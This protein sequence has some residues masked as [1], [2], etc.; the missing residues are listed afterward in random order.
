M[1][2]EQTTSTPVDATQ[3]VT[4][5]VEE[6][7][8]ETLPLPKLDTVTPEQPAT[9]TSEDIP[10]HGNEDSPVQAPDRSVSATPST[11]AQEGNDA[12]YINKIQTLEKQVALL[13]KIADKAAMQR[14]APEDVGPSQ[15][16]VSVYEGQI[17]L[18]WR[19]IRDK[20]YLKNHELVEE[21]VVE[22]TLA[23]RSTRILSYK[24]TIT[25]VEKI[26]VNVTG[27][28]TKDAIDASGHRVRRH[29]YEFEHEGEAYA[30]ELPFIN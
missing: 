18:S 23:D 20:V 7:K 9:Q 4:E 17:V 14:H 21:Q 16:L 25:D 12:A 2:D 1:N 27:T 13:L 6:R 5:S 26:T 29:F 3:S 19:T 10:S 28:S 8:E 24:Q 22:Y 15:I 30:I 11:S